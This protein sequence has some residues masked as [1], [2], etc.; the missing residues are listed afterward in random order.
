VSW[1]RSQQTVVKF[2]HTIDHL[3]PMLAGRMADCNDDHASFTIRVNKI[4]ELST[5][6]SAALL[7]SDD[8]ANRVASGGGPMPNQ[9]TGP[10]DDRL[11]LA[12]LTDSAH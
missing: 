3:L 5:A 12:K 2:S 4:A 6:V 10:R 9:R 11:N 7:R 8:L 1:Y